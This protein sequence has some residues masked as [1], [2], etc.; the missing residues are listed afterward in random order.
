[1]KVH[2]PA[3]LPPPRERA[4]D[5][6]CIGGWVGPRAGLDTVV[7]TSQPLP[8]LEPPI[9]HPLAQRHIIIII[10]II[11]VVTGEGIAQSV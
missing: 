8:G 5:T 7:K 9:I 4:P 2:V 11:V 1:M 6:H 10:I 3:A